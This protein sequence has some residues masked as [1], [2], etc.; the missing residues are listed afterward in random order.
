MIATTGEEILEE[1][2]GLEEGRDDR[3]FSKVG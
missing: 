2:H 3:L 1:L